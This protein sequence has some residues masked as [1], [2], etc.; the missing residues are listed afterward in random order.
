MKKKVDQGSGRTINLSQT[1][2]LLETKKKLN[3]SYILLITIDL[4]GKKI[5]VKGK[6]VVSRFD[7]SSVC[8][9]TGIKFIGPRDAQLE[10]V[11]SFVKSYHHRKYKDSQ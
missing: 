5:K 3:G 4:E 2:T 6:V 11:V 8:Y 9:L 7:E 1:G 10:A